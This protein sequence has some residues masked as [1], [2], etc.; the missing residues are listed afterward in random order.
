MTPAQIQAVS[1]DPK[2]FL[3]RGRAL[4]KHITVMRKRIE[5]WRQIGESIS[6]ILKNDADVRSSEGYKQ[7][8]VENAVCS[9]V[10]LENEIVAEIER[11]VR[12]ERDICEAIKVLVSDDT[13]KMILEM[14]YLDGRS[15]EHVAKYLGYS[16]DR[17]YRLH[18]QA[19]QELRRHKKDNGK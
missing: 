19:L 12:V 17:V 9:I 14:R 15:W 16:I 6:A 7:S 3:S 13:Q 11:L 18:G 4:K 2:T 1:A 10:D 8:L 5:G